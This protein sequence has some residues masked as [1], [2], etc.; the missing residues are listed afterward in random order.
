MENIIPIVN[1]QS[2]IYV[3]REHKVMLDRDL[4]ELYMVET[5]VLNQAVKRNI[6]RFPNDF[7]FQLSCEELLNWKSQFVTS[8]SIKMGLRKA[9]YVFTELGIAMLSSVLNSDKAIKINIQIM[10]TF[11]QLR[12]FLATNEEIK[13]KLQEHDYMISYLVES[14]DELLHPV[15][16]ETKHKFGFIKD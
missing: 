6:E 11:V 3:I 4:A 2:K 12:E 13:K 8:N 9:P 7:M 10:R 15:V 1:I 5:K 16:E 14:V